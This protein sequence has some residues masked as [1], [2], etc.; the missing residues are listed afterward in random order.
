MDE[1]TERKYFTLSHGR[2]WQGDEKHVLSRSEQGKEA[3]CNNTIT[4]F[5][6]FDKML[7]IS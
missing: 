7:E 2:K 1:Y 4:N 6:E 5:I 3:G